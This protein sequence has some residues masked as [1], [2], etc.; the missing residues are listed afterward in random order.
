MGMMEYWKTL[1]QVEV[2]ED[3]RA[4]RA[5]RFKNLLRVIWGRPSWNIVRRG[6]GQAWDIWILKDGET[7]GDGSQ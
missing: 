2:K 1:L 3:V 6:W 7:L 4:E 5:L